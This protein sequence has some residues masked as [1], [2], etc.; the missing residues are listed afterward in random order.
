MDADGGWRL[1][2]RGKGRHMGRGLKMVLLEA[3][4]ARDGRTAWL[5]GGPS[6]LD[7]VQVGLAR[8][9]GR[10]RWSRRLGSRGERMELFVWASTQ[11]GLMLII[12]D[13]LQKMGRW[14]LMVDGGRWSLAWALTLSPRGRDGRLLAVWSWVVDHRMGGRWS[15]GR[16]RRAAD[17]L[18][19]RLDHGYLAID[20]VEEGGRDGFQAWTAKWVSSQ[21]GVMEICLMCVWIG[22]AALDLESRR[23]GRPF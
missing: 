18:D 22:R 12:A 1:M 10:S 21:L 4:L 2:V 7:L 23:G 19:G 20:R 3:L 14:V 17:G 15:L 9:I 8:T 5:I 13:L 11:T 6:W 16:R